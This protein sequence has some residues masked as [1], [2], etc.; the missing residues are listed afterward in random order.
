MNYLRTAEFQ[1]QEEV[2]GKGVQEIGGGGQV[3]QGVEAGI[4]VSETR[5]EVVCQLGPGA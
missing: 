2:Y 4:I 3:H 1:A 5:S